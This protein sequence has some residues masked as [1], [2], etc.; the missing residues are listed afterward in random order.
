MILS[1]SMS[2]YR[3]FS[4]KVT[5]D[6][7]SHSNS[8]RLAS[9][10]IS[11]GNFNIV[12][13]AGIYG[14]NNCGKT[15]FLSGVSTIKRVLLGKQEFD[16]VPNLFTGDPVS[17]FSIA[18]RNSGSE[19]WHEYSFAFDSRRGI[20]SKEKLIAF[21]KDA[22]NHR[23]ERIIFEKN[24]DGNVY[25]L[26]GE[27]SKDTLSLVSSSLPLM[28]ALSDANEKVKKYRG[29]LFAAGSS[30]EIIS[31]YNIPFDKTIGV[32]KG[33]DKTKKDAIVSFVKNADLSLNDLS[34]EPNAKVNISDEKGRDISENALRMAPGLEDRAKLFS[35][36]MGK[37]V[38]SL[39]FDS[40]GTKK[41]EALSSYVLEALTEGKTLFVDELDSGLHFR[42]TRAIVSL[43][44]NIGNEKGQMVFTTHD[45]MLLNTKRL[46]RK[47]QIWFIEKNKDGAVDLYPLS[48]FTAADGTRETSDLIKE[49]S[50]G[51]FSYIPNPDFV[52]SLIKSLPKDSK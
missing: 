50:R 42:L 10:L 16:P 4:E 14:A 51:D 41:I 26:F 33:T 47:E 46:M 6:L 20:F 3:V 23:H 15:S 32:L 48:R 1:I 31:M 8:R 2:N 28:Y 49:Y 43:F 39:V 17:S 37:K 11:N 19:S 35:T 36:Y 52:D 12:K 9:N 40:T 18:F 7:L 45:V 13:S 29:E 5:L 44:N 27:R 34:Y 24:V 38:P 22:S 30:I 21:G 25:S